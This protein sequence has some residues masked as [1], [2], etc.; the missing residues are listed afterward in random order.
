MIA[1]P[2]KL[3]DGNV[4]LPDVPGTGIDFKEDILEKY[5]INL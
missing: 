4:I 5:K 3:K 2:Y 1:E